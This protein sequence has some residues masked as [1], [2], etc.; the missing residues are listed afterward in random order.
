MELSGRPNIKHCTFLTPPPVLS[1]SLTWIVA[2][3]P[4]LPV[5]GQ[6]HGLHLPQLLVLADHGLYLGRAAVIPLV[7]V[8][9]TQFPVLLVLL[10]GGVAGPVLQLHPVHHGAGEHVVHHCIAESVAPRLV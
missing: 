7:F 8:V 10:T 2:A 9:F 6:R 5:G 3:G 4:I 1:P